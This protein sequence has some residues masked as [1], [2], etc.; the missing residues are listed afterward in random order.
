MRRVR[1]QRVNRRGARLLARGGA[2]LSPLSLDTSPSI[3]DR[4]ID[5]RDTGA[6]IGS[7][8]L[9]DRELFFTTATDV[10]LRESLV[11]LET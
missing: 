6:A 7:V 2:S 10:R 4:V 1:Q 9:G 11:R 8:F 3:G 5:V